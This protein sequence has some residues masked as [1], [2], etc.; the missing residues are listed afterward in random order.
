ME[1]KNNSGAIFKNTNKKEEKHPDYKGKINCNG[2]EMEIALWIKT[3]AKGEKF[4][5]VALSEPYVKTATAQPATTTDDG[6]P[7]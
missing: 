4:F 7:F 6:A 1:T 5:G 3:S 2:K